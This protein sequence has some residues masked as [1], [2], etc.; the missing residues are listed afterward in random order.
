MY[1]KN[2]H[3]P[4]LKELLSLTKKR[5]NQNGSFLGKSTFTTFYTNVTKFFHLQL[6]VVNY[7]PDLHPIDHFNELV[8]ESLDPRKKNGGNRV[9]GN[10]NPTLEFQCFTNDIE[11]RSIGR[12]SSFPGKKKKRQKKE[13]T[14]LF[15]LSQVNIG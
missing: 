8:S 14:S 2:G 10:R 11:V 4:T 7:S 13:I 6:K 5:I 15:V 9:T 3:E 1:R 12:R